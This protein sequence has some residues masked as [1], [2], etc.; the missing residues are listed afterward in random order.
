MNN[1]D[2]NSETIGLNQNKC[3]TKSN[4]VPILDISLFST[5]DFVKISM[6]R[7]RHFSVGIFICHKN[8]HKS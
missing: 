1:N 2:V 3:Y 5:D 8:Q 6:G 4:M 7:S